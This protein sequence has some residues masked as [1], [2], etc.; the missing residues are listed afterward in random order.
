MQVFPALGDAYSAALKQHLAG[1]DALGLPRE[2][3]LV[4][5]C[6]RTLAKAV[7]AAQRVAAGSMDLLEGDLPFAEAEADAARPTKRR[8]PARARA[9][10]PRPQAAPP[11]Q[12]AAKS[13]AA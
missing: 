4:V 13:T 7:K 2:A 8:R 6:R 11:Q 1:F 9:K 10:R 3:Q 5:E 12:R